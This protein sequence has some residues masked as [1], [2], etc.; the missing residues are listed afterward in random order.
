M[1]RANAIGR[2]KN[3]SDTVVSDNAAQKRT[4]RIISPRGRGGSFIIV[5]I[6]RGGRGRGGGGR[7]RRR[8]R[9]RRR[10][11]R[12]RRRRRR[13]RSWRRNKPYPTVVAIGTEFAA[14]VLS[15]RTAVIANS[16]TCP[17]RRANAIG[18]AYFNQGATRWRGRRL[19]R[20]W[21]SGRRVGSRR[22]RGRKFAKFHVQRDVDI[23]VG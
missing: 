9:R 10:R 16:V 22:R 15:P 12:H 18:R 2:T 3:A 13:H 21:R 17:M 8:Q 7:R 20:R 14:V 23:F 6:I 4:F 1:R 5:R 19:R 11:R